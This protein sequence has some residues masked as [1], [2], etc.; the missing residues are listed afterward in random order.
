M[1]NRHLIGSNGED[2]KPLISIKE[3]EILMSDLLLTRKINLDRK[4]RRISSKNCEDVRM[5]AIPSISF[6]LT[7]S[8]ISKRPEHI[9]NKSTCLARTASIKNYLKELS[10]QPDTLQTK[11]FQL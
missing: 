7:V 11:I 9:G 1:G 6:A 3:T 8:K 10:N 4:Y 2:F 5:I